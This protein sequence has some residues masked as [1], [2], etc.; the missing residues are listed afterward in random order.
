MPD[1]NRIA[2]CV[3]LLIIPV[4]PVFHQFRIVIESYNNV[5]IMLKRIHEAQDCQKYDI[6]EQ[7][8]QIGK[9][10]IQEQYR[11][12]TEPDKN[13]SCC[14]KPLIF[15]LLKK[16]WRKNEYAVHR[17]LYSGH[18]QPLQHFHKFMLDGM[19]GKIIP[20]V[21]LDDVRIIHMMPH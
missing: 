3:S 4:T 14:T 19:A 10:R 12:Q 7:V 17:K 5:I 8:T 1:R 9:W 21:E 16:E 11:K 13:N 2:E 15:F 6:G 18:I 20:V